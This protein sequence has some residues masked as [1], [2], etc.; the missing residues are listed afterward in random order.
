MSLQITTNINVDFYDNKYVMINAKQYDDKSRLISVTCYN[1][2]D[3]YNLSSKNHTAYIKYKKADGRWILN[4]CTINH[5][6]QV[7]VELTDQMLAASGICYV[8][9]FVVNKG[10]A[11]VNIDTGSIV[12]IDGSSVLTTKAFYIDVQ[13]AS[14]DNSVFESSDEYSGLTN[15]ISRAEAEYNDV[16][17]SAKSYAIGTKNYARENDEMDNSKYYSQISKSYAMGGTG[18]RTGENTSNSKYYSQLA[19]NSADSADESEANAKTYM[20]NAK[21]YMDNAKSSEVNTSISESNALDSERSAKNSEIN[22]LES[23]MNASASEENAKTS[24]TNAKI[25]ETNAKISE[26]NA[27]ISE[28]N[29]K[30]SETNAKTSETNAKTSE[31]NAA[32]SEANAKNAQSAAEVAEQNAI[33][34]ASQSAEQ[35]AANAVNNVFDLMNDNLTYCQEAANK[36]ENSRQL[37]LDSETNASD[38]EQNAETYMNNAE[39]SETN[40]LNSANKAQSY[41]I[42]GTGTRDDEDI[43]NAW[44]YYKE[45]KDMFDGLNV[46]FVPKGTI[47]FSELAIV[48]EIAV[49]GYVYNIKDDFV[50]DE[51]FREGSGTAYAAGTN[52]YYIIDEDGEGKWD[53]LGGNAS[54]T[55]TVDEVKSYLGI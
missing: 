7:L 35:A 48:K 10:S 6:G 49:A 19:H 39:I 33:Q 29:A 24:E 28:V 42:G 22:S 36:A 14:V 15:L 2:G 32:T 21:S 5:R 45:I 52:V 31:T 43:D 23:E 55:A 46:V 3:I 17:Q 51:T 26:T 27:K 47:F 40:A 37:A 25:S 30:T 13:E 53:C 54:L 50:T 34:A 9:L 44:F 38:S 20:D 18:L 41:A 11:I 4:C 16:I 8:D 1:Q 12:T